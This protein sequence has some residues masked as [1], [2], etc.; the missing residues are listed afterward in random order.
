MLRILPVVLFLILSPPRLFSMP[1]GGL[2]PSESTTL[3][4]EANQI[5]ALGKIII[6]HPESPLIDRI[7]SQREA[8]MQRLRS[9]RGIVEIGSREQPTFDISP[10]YDLTLQKYK[11]SCEIA[12]MRM[13]IE[14]LT[15]I[16]ISEEMIFSSLRIQDGPLSPEG[17]WG[18]PDIGFV[19]SLT[20]SQRLRTGYGIYEKPLE[21]YGQSLGLHTVSSSIMS[22]DISRARIQLPLLLSALKGKK[23]IILW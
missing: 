15:P 1:S 20:G 12:A 2:T 3:N 18:D 17:I 8:I 7:F 16:K 21:K 10:L 5:I 4:R 9:L 23:R 13:V 19:G 11:L 22:Y 6:S 14:S